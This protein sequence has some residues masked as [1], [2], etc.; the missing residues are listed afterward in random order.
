MSNGA[1]N[2]TNRLGHGI[3]SSGGICAGQLVIGAGIERTLEYIMDSVFS[4]SSIPA[5]APYEIRLEG[6]L[7]GL[8]LRTLTA[9]SGFPIQHAPTGGA[10]HG[11]PTTLYMN[12]NSNSPKTRGIVANTSAGNITLSVLLLG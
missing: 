8:E 6:S 3:A 7:T 4:S 9:V 11:E 5:F 12:Q 1:S 10:S 2:Q